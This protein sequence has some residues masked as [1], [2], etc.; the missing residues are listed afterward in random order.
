MARYASKQIVAASLASK[1]EVRLS[2]AIGL[3]QPISIDIDTYGTE[4]ISIQKIKDLLLKHFDFSPRGM[5]DKLD[6]RKPIYK[7][8]ATYG[9]FGRDDLQLSWEEMDLVDTLK[10]YLN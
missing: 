9:H 6:L 1:C 2:Y 4:N 8:V 5:I 7:Q 3:T 10:Q